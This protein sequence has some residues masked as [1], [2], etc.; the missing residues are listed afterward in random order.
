MYDNH[1]I[2]PMYHLFAQ[3]AYDP[4]VIQGYEAATGNFGPAAYIEFIEPVIK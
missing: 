3:V 4:G 2:V 1:I